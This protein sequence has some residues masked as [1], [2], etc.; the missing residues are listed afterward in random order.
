VVARSRQRT[1]SL[2]TAARETLREIWLW[3]ADRYGAQH[4]DG[5]LRFL[6]NAIGTLARPEIAGRPVPGRSDLR[7]LLFRRRAG[8]HGHL[9]VFHAIGEQITVL[10]IFHTAQDW[11]SSINDMQGE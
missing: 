10:Q 2:S 4:A 1:I 5:Y 8:A 7:Y 3:N 9:A 11:Q 6:E